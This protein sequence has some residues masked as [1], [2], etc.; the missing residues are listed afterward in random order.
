M[1]HLQS[2]RLDLDHFGI[3]Y[4]KKL[5]M[6]SLTSV[7]ITSY[8]TDINNL[9]ILT[10]ARIFPRVVSFK[11]YKIDDYDNNP[12]IDN[13]TIISLVET[14]PVLEKIVFGCCCRLSD[15]SLVYVASKLRNLQKLIG[16]G[17]SKITDERVSALLIGCRK[18]DTIDLMSTAIS[19]RSLDAM[20]QSAESLHFIYL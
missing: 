16:Y 13:S 7:K 17:H 15:K 12:Y 10:V 4:I 20:V 14:N 19:D 8:D 18:L 5:V 1:T 6:P 9:I 3:Q 2:L 11:I